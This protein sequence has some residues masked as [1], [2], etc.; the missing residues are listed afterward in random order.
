MAT[1]YVIGSV[2]SVLLRFNPNLEE[3]RAQPRGEP[4]AVRSRRVTLPII[5]PGIYAG[6]LFAFMVSFGDVP[7]SLFSRKS[8][9]RNPSASRDL[10]FHGVRFRPR[11]VLAISTLIVF[12]SLVILWLIQKSVG[13]DVMLRSGGSG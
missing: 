4:V 5:M 8:E 2:G 9:V 10:P 12:A 11:A 7:I 6:A 1:P 13:L 3:G